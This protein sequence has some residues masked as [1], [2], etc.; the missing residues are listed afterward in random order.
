[1]SQHAVE[2]IRF[3]AESDVQVKRV[4]TLEVEWSSR[5][6][7]ERES[8]PVVHLKEAVQPASLVDFERADEPKAKE[9][10]IEATRFLGIPA[11]VRIVMQTLDHLLLPLIERR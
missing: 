5:N 6:L 8:G 1:L 9:V 4:L 2:H 3:D 7:E 11:A 10:L